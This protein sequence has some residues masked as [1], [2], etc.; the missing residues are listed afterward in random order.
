MYILS[1]KAK[2]SQQARRVGKADN[3]E[4]YVYD[5][6]TDL[7]TDMISVTWSVGVSHS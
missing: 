1:T 4:G 6:Y 3:K 5:L 7:V 2:S